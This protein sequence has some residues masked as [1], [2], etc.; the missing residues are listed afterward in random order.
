MKK[1]TWDLYAP[2]YELAMRDDIRIYQFMYDRIPTI[3]R[4]KEVL[5]LATGPGLLQVFWFELFYFW[6]RYGIM[7]HG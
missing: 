6:R 3:I 7:R 4:D 2:I 1:R 5:E